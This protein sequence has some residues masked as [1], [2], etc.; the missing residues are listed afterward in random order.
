MVGDN[1][2]SKYDKAVSLK[3]PILDEAGF[4]VLLEQGPEEATKVAQI[5]ADPAGA[6]PAGA[7][8]ADTVSAD[9][10][11]A[12]AEAPDADPAAADPASDS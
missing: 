2:G 9:T 7:E 12:G 4:L 8:P 11:S 1:P 6:E 3:V 10:D 5:G